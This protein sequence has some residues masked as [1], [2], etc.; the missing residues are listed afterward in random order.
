MSELT[1]EQAIALAKSGF[2]ES[3]SYR[4]R[5]MFQMFEDRLCM[6]FDVFHE[7][8][9]MANAALSSPAL[10]KLRGKE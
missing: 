6:P 9:K 7:A 3:M 4:D 5:A 8:F 1:K 2:W 10:L